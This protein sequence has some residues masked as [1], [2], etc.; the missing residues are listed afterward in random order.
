MVEGTPM[1]GVSP[2]L[3]PHLFT[4]AG[5]SRMCRVGSSIAPPPDLVLQADERLRVAKVKLVRLWCTDW[6]E[7]VGGKTVVIQLGGVGIED[8]LE[9]AAW[10]GTRFTEACL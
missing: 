5:H 7:G 10:S 4:W 8:Q 3:L 1:G 2:V 9:M 6:R